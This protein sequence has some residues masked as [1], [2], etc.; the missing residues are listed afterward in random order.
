MLTAKVLFKSLEHS[1]RTHPR[2]LALGWCPHHPLHCALSPAS[3]SPHPQPCMLSACICPLTILLVDGAWV[4][5]GC[6]KRNEDTSARDSWLVCARLRSK[7]ELRHCRSCCKPLGGA[8]APGGSTQLLLCTDGMAELL[9]LGP[10]PPPQI[11]LCQNHSGGRPSNDSMCFGCHG[12]AAMY[13]W[14][15]KLA[16]GFPETLESCT[17]RHKRHQRHMRH[18]GRLWDAVCHMRGMH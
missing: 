7:C 12:R 15:T 10:V 1:P 18:T 3:R 14:S 4:A 5:L 9:L 2:A 8:A 13:L 11:S 17:E 6:A 16:G